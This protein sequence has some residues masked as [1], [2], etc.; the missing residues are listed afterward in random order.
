MCIGGLATEY[1]YMQVQGPII[2]QTAFRKTFIIN[3]LGEKN[4][5][6]FP[7]NRE[8]IP[9]FIVWFCNA[10]FNLLLFKGVWK[11]VHMRFFCGGI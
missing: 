11:K 2:L 10:S 9:Q 7:E 3:N 5:L 1:V 4:H 6:R 8:I